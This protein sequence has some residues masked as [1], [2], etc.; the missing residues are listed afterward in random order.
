MHPTRRPAP[1]SS[2]SKV[3]HMNR[4]SFFPRLGMSLCLALLVPTIALASEMKTEQRWNFTVDSAAEFEPIADQIRQDMQDGRYSHLEERDRLAVD[5]DLSRVTRLLIKRDENNSK[6]AKRDEVELINAQERINAILIDNEA[7]RIV[8]KLEAKVG[9]R[10]KSKNCM[11]VRDWAMV[12]AAAERTMRDM[13][14]GGGGLPRLR[15]DE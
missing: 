4:L 15:D 7:D 2:G 11:S 8:C 14:A 10:M 9:T 3:Q 5:T 6:L 1:T 13:R 12:N